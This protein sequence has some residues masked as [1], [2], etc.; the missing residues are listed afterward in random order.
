MNLRSLKRRHDGRPLV[1]FSVWVRRS[2]PGAAWQRLTWRG[3]SRRFTL[4]AGMQCMMHH[5]TRES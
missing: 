1:T 4:D 3:R 2:E 5:R